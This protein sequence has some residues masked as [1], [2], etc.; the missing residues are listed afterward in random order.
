MK[1]F[2]ASER[3]EAL[4]RIPNPER[5]KRWEQVSGEGFPSELLKAADE[6]MRACL[7]RCDVALADAQWLAGEYSLA[8]MAAVPFVDRIRNLRPEF[9]KGGRYP[10]LDAWYGRLHARPAF[11]KAMNFRDDPR[12]AEMINL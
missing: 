3:E 7:A 8:D 2:T 4:A 11:D 1:D 9:F 12:A 5:R 10:H 6:K